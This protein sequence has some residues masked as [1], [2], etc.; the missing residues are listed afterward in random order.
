[1]SSPQHV[2]ERAGLGTAPFRWLRC[3]HRVGPI[4]IGTE[5]GVEHWAGAPGQPMGSC[6]F[7]GQGIA[8]CHVIGSAD[9]REFIVGCDCV[10]KT[11]D[12]GLRKSINKIRTVARHEAESRRIAEGEAWFNALPDGLDLGLSPSGRSSFAEYFAWMMRNA[13]NAGKLRAIRQARKIV[14]AREEVAS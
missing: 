7:C 14:T 10:R 6:Q 13:G 1:M 5:G 9:G 4:L 3:E 8:E 12:A 2:F 11:G